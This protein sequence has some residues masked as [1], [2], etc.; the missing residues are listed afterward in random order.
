[1]S[2]EAEIR[3]EMARQNIGVTD[4]AERIGL[5]R[6]YLGR[7]LRG[8]GDIKVKHVIDIGAVLGVPASELFH[9]AERIGPASSRSRVLAEEGRHDGDA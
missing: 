6:A 5:K 1:M 8:C 9:R 7:H 4:L 3:A 2:V